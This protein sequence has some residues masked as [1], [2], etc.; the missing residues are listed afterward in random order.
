[1]LMIGVNVDDKLSVF[2][3]LSRPFLQGVNYIHLLGIIDSFFVVA[4]CRGPPTF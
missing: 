4:K 2:I 1:M 3:G